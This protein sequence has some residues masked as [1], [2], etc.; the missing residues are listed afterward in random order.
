M[1]DDAAHDGETTT[2]KAAAEAR[3][4]GEIPQWTRLLL[5]RAPQAPYS[6]SP[7]RSAG[8]RIRTLHLWRRFESAVLGAGWADKKVKR[9]GEVD[10]T[11]HGG[12]RSDPVPVQEGGGREAT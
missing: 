12:G 11:L 5:H 6:N 4:R 3:R 1:A 9:Q 7:P 2:R 8:Y 10:R